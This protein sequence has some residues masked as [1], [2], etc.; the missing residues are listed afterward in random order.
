MFTDEEPKTIGCG[1]SQIVADFELPNPVASQ[2]LIE[3]EDNNPHF[4]EDVDVVIETVD[5]TRLATN[6]AQGI[7]AFPAK[8]ADPIDSSKFRVRIGQGAS[9]TTTPKQL[10]AAIG[11]IPE[12]IS[13]SSV[14]VAVQYIELYADMQGTHGPTPELPNSIACLTEPVTLEMVTHLAG[15]NL[16][17]RKTVK[18][19]RARSDGG[20]AFEYTQTD[21]PTSPG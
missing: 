12:Y 11:K 18:Y 7:I 14:D 6:I 8:D 19:G 10:L 5:V 16:P 4:I 21:R 2:R 3:L 1:I 9:S 15:S 13:G 17:P 20:I